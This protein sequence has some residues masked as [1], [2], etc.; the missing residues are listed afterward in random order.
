MQSELQHD[1]PARECCV[2]A[3]VKQGAPPLI[4]VGDERAV[5]CSKWS[6]FGIESIDVNVSF[7]SSILLHLASRQLG[8][9]LAGKRGGDRSGLRLF[10]RAF[11]WLRVWRRLAQ[12]QVATFQIWSGLGFFLVLGCL[13][14]L[15]NRRGRA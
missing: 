8:L 2:I 7:H 9:A 12:F 1:L 10:R 14:S 6:G 5:V 15:C 3:V 4:H 11:V 13:L